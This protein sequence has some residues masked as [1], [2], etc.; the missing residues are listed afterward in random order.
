MVLGIGADVVQELLHV[1]GQGGG[2]V[3]R[4][5]LAT[6]QAL[7]H[8][9]HGQQILHH[10]VGTETG[11]GGAQLVGELRFAQ[12]ASLLLNHKVDDV[13]V[14]DEFGVL[15]G[16]LGVDVGGVGHAAAVHLIEIAHKV[17]LAINHTYAEE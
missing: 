2:G 13:A 7:E 6:A 14:T 10:R 11:L 12:V 8:K 17:R 16:Q 1:L 5:A 9:Q 4:D 15:L 3:G